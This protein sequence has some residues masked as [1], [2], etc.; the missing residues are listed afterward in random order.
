MRERWRSRMRRSVT[1]VVIVMMVVLIGT[2]GAAFAEDRTAAD[3]ENAGRSFAS[4][5]GEGPLSAAVRREGARLAQNPAPVAPQKSW[6][7]QHPVMTGALIGTAAGAALSR[8]DAIGGRN[9][10]PRVA[11]LGTGS[12]AF[13]GLLTSVVQKRRTNEEI[14]VGTK[15]ALVSSVVGA[16]A[17]TLMCVSYCGGN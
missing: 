10:D 6:I 5:V 8:T 2:Q 7:A 4:V 9:H 13:A 12:G 3:S 16:V 15:V 1:L 17:L 14:G 11:L